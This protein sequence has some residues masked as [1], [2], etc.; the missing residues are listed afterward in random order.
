MRR[1]ERAVSL[2][3]RT[4]DERLIRLHPD[5]VAM[6]SPS[7]A[8]DWQILPDRTLERGAIRVETASGGV[9]DGPELW[10]RAIAEALRQC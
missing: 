10:R 2:L 8:A 7:L 6:L 3:A 4:D 9:E 5:D 1:I